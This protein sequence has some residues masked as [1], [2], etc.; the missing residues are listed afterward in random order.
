MDDMDKGI[1]S[2]AVQEIFDIMRLT[3]PEDEAVEHITRVV[4]STMFLVLQ[5]FMRHVDHK[6]QR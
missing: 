1:I 3:I 2:N 4:K 6:Y 5:E